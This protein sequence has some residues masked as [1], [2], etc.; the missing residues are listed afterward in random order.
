MRKGVE[1]RVRRTPR[2]PATAAAKELFPVPGG[3]YN[4]TPRWNGIPRSLY[5]LRLPM[6]LRSRQTSLSGMSFPAK[7]RG[8]KKRGGTHSCRSFRSFKFCRL[9]RRTLSTDRFDLVGLPFHWMHRS[10][11]H[12]NAKRSLHRRQPSKLQRDEQVRERRETDLGGLAHLAQCVHTESVRRSFGV[13]LLGNVDEILEGPA[14]GDG[15]PAKE[16]QSEFGYD[17]DL[18]TARSRRKSLWSAVDRRMIWRE[19]RRTIEIED[20]S[21]LT[22]VAIP[23]QPASSASSK[24]ALPPLVH[25]LPLHFPE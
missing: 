11:G 16:R 17:P 9:G 8:K 2:S 20:H 10:I 18:K 22:A 24:A 25:L 7:G 4:N 14:G 15:R 5:Q 19:G 13:G 3:P 12:C 23:A 1:G 6:N 21:S